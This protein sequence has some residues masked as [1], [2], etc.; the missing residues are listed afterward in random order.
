MFS[1]NQAH[2]VF[3]LWFKTYEFGNRQYCFN[4]LEM[5]V[6]AA[7]ENWI[8]VPRRGKGV[9]SDNSVVHPCYITNHHKLKWDKK[10]AH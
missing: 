5:K 1:Q 6:L 7:F 8:V 9:F 10:T 2:K 3:I 4:M